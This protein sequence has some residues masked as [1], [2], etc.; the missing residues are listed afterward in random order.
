MKIT[1][2]TAAVLIEADRRASAGLKR[3]APMVEASAKEIVPVVSGDLQ[4]SISAEV[5]DNRLTVGSPLI[6]APKVEMDKPYLRPALYKHLGDI[7]RI[8][9][10]GR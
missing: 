5:K 2:N 8:F 3:I 9:K 7:Q 1:D 4:D 10:A 6:Y